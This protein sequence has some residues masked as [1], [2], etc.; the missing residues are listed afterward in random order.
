MKLRTACQRS[1]QRRCKTDKHE[2]GFRSNKRP[3]RAMVIAF[4]SLVKKKDVRLEENYLFLLNIFIRPVKIG[5][6]C[7]PRWTNNSTKNRYVRHLICVHI[8]VPQGG[9]NSVH[10]FVHLGGQ[11]RYNYRDSSVLCMVRTLIIFK[12]RNPEMKNYEIRTEKRNLVKDNQSEI[13]KWERCRSS[14]APLLPRM[15]HGMF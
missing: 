13:P 10:I 11:T 8:F 15:Y 12:E 4:F 6:F 14:N 3:S 5:W 2:L 9:Q 1:E 7:P